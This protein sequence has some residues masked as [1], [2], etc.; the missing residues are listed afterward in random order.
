MT[1]VQ[2]YLALGIPF[3]SLV[4][5]MVI[6]NSRINDMRDLLRAEIQ[7]LRLETQG[8]FKAIHVELME[9]R[10]ILDRLA[11]GLDTLTGKVIEMDN[12]H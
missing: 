2:L 4:V 1:N 9:Q 7:G 12:R 10:R 5:A 3:L 6:S 8:E 11:T